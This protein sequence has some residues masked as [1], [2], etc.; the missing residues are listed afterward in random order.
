MSQFKHKKFV[1]GEKSKELKPADEISALNFW[2]HHYVLP[3]E[4]FEVAALIK[5]RIDKLKIIAIGFYDSPA[6]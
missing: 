3:D 2:L 6:S 4:K 1:L 5:A